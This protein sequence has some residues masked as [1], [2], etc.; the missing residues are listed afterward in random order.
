MGALR[1]LAGI[2]TAASIALGCTTV[3]PT[4]APGPTFSSPVPRPLPTLEPSPSLVPLSALADVDDGGSFGTAGLWAIRGDRLLISTDVGTTWMTRKLPADT[5]SLFGTW[6]FEALDA[7]HAWLVRYG[8]ETTGFDGSPDEILHYLISSTRDGGATW[9]TVTAP[10][11]YPGT[12][13][14]VSF[15]DPD[16]GYLLATATRLSLGTSTVL[17]TKDGGAIWTV[18]GT[19]KWLD[20]QFAAS[21]PTTIW[22]GGQEQA[23]GTFDEPIL[24][25][26]RDGGRTWRDTELPGLTGTTEASCGCYLAGPPVF[27][28]ASSGFVTVVNSFGS[29][30]QPGSWIE[31]TTDGGRSWS[32]AASRPG[33]DATGATMLDSSHWLM[34]QVNPTL[35][36]ESVDRGSTWQTV[37]S[38]GVWPA[39]FP[40]WIHAFDASTAAAFVQGS[41][42]PASAVYALL[43]TTDGGRTWRELVPD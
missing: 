11:N 41:G 5:A 16:H 20:A 32:E 22:S 43:L 7:R 42:D 8:P 10:G 25:V 35:V 36:A 1:T 2:A 13:P 24:G 37:A 27:P 33:I 9:E 17:R 40:V 28:S 14:A 31:T 26:S 3:N 4:E 23:G 29:N 12:I 38:D 6:R 21:D 18:A 34:A 30:G 15:A 39:V 19:G